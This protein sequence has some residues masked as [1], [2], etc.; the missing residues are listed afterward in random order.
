MNTQ[1]IVAVLK[2][3]INALPHDALASAVTDHIRQQPDGQK[4]FCTITGVENAAASLAAKIG[5]S[6]T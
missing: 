6:Q 4:H 3:H 2:A 5:A 1:D